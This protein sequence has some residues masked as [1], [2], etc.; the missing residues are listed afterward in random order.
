MTNRTIYLVI[1][2]ILLCISSVH[3]AE[4]QVVIGVVADGP[5][6]FV[7]RAI[8]LIDSEIQAITKS[9]SIVVY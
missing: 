3:A 9:V 4:K 6:I 1:V 8:E 2:Q 5:S 7:D